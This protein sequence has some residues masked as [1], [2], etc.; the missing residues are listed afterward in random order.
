MY[1]DVINNL[2]LELEASFW[3]K[4]DSKTTEGKKFSFPADWWEA[5][6]ERWFP[7]ALLKKYP[8]KRCHQV[9]Q[10]LT[11]TTHVCPHLNWKSPT[12]HLEFIKGS[13]PEEFYRLEILF[14]QLST[15]L[16][17]FKHM[18]PPQEMEEIDK[19]FSNAFDILGLFSL[20][21]QEQ[22]KDKFR[23]WQVDN[24]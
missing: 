13:M 8:V 7:K 22:A 1:H 11:S 14:R 4:T 23:G 19:I 16:Y 21:E 17:Q 6:K 15:Y 18:V 20:V 24:E 12:P 9:I 5:F 10:T 2:V 3:G